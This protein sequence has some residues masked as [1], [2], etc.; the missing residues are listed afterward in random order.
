MD[1]DDTEYGRAEKKHLSPEQ[2][3]RLREKLKEIDEKL[4]RLQW[5]EKEH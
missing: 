2:F 4:R 3:R 5:S 1:T